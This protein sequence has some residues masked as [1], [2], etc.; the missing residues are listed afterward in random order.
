MKD[1]PSQLDWTTHLSDAQRA[2]ASLA[3]H[4][5]ALNELRDAATA[6]VLAFGRGAGIDLNPDAVQASID[7]PYV[8]VPTGN[9]NEW[10]VITWRG[11]RDM[12]VVGW[13]VSQN[14]AFT[15]SV[16]SRAMGFVSHVPDW[17]RDA[18]GWQPPAFAAS[19]D[20]SKTVVRVT[21]GDRQAFQR[22]YRAFLDGT[23]EGGFKLKR[24]RAWIDLL[25][26]L[27]EDG[28]L[29]YSP[30]PVR[31]EHWDAARPSRVALRDYQQPYVEDFL[32]NGALT[33]I[34]PPGGGK[35]HIALALIERLVGK[36]YV[37]CENTILCEQWQ[38][39]LKDYAPH[40][41]VEVLTYAAATRRA[42]SLR[43]V[44][45]L[46]DEAHRLPA[47]TWSAL[48]FVEVE[49]RA[50]LTGTAWREKRQAM[51]PA[52]AGPP[53]VIPWKELID[54][55]V[56]NRPRVQVVVV[57][58]IASK[59]QFIRATLAKHPDASALIY[60]DS[61][62][63]GKELSNT[64]GLPFIHGE[65][66]DKYAR[67][68]GARQRIVSKMAEQGIDIPDLTLV[69][70][71]D[72]SRTGDSRV[73]EGQRIGRLL[74]GARRGEYYLLFTLDEF[75]RFRGRL[76]G[77]E[78]E[79]GDVIEYVDLTGAGTL[80][81]ALERAPRKPAR[82]ARAKEV[83]QPGDEAGAL[84]ASKAIA[85]LILDHEKRLG[86]TRRG[87]MGKAFRLLWKSDGTSE[88]LRLR[89]GKSPKAW[90]PYHA[91]LN[92]LVKAGLAKQVD[93]RYYLDRARVN[94]LKQ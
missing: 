83:V 42:K 5:A 16:V 52:L 63:Y 54:A 19:L 55:G 51:I 57:P 21:A 66:P 32:R 68:M 79:M 67:V 93:K 77:V 75:A 38:A 78:A 35:T 18:M 30:K 76:L 43:G 50:G 20:N 61:I 85:R 41:D 13:V 48:A 4:L 94:A 39:R 72:V 92:M 40:A 3:E 90:E 7:K 71:A 25:S 23:V 24:G 14:E 58:S 44:F 84:L 33:V 1:Q 36:Q 89:D 10:N 82:V 27:I 56:L 62:A 64:L 81:A 29:P 9:P 31:P 60:C 12:P 17:M 70:E 34:L 49:Y 86:A 59:L 6:Q 2:A 15:V 37:F 46:F 45:A 53:R 28:I 73:S 11:R 74:H 8:L 91:A 22:R 88:E 65:T 80:R 69:I 47:E 87:Y 26:H